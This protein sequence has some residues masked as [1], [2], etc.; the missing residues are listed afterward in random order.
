MKSS[1]YDDK[2]FLDA[3]SHES[4]HEKMI[5][6]FKEKF[7]IDKNMFFYIQKIIISRNKQYS[8]Y[9]TPNEISNEEFEEDLALDLEDISSKNLL[10][11]N[12]IATLKSI[13]LVAQSIN[14]KKLKRSIKKSNS[15]L[16]SKKV[17]NL[18]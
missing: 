12:L 10:E 2:N 3:L 6:F 15:N 8:H 7:N 11:D 13:L 17:K 9:Q 18:K 14:N 16:S 1:D 5:K 4:R